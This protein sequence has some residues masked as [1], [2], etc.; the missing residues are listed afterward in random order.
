MSTNP[1]NLLF[2]ASRR[3][4]D[5]ACEYA[6]DVDSSAIDDAAEDKLHQAALDYAA[7]ANAI[8][9]QRYGI[10]PAI[11]DDVRGRG[12]SSTTRTPRSTP[13]ASTP[14]STRWRACSAACKA[15]ESAE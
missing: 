6:Q 14:A 1:S 2:F 8:D 4:R 12:G 11:A 10:E 3:L 5:A 13:T 9:G 7:V 15:K